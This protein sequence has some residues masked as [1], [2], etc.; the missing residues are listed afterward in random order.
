MFSTRVGKNKEQF[1]FL[2]NG[3]TLDYN[4]NRKI[5]QLS[6]GDLKILTISKNK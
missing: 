6:F 2:Y 1:K 5:W 4:D 3:H